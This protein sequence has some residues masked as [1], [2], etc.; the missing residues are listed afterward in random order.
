MPCKESDTN[1]QETYK[2]DFYRKEWEML[3]FCSMYDMIWEGD[4]CSDVEPQVLKDN[5]IACFEKEKP[6][7]YSK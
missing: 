1:L 6:N 7:V 4:I 2:S 5:M 3:S